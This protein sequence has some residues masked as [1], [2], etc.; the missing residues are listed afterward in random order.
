MPSCKL[1]PVKCL[2]GLKGLLWPGSLMLSA[3]WNVPLHQGWFGRSERL[4]SW[5]PRE[6]L[7]ITAALYRY[8]WARL[9]VLMLELF[10]MCSSPKEPGHPQLKLIDVMNNQWLTMFTFNQRAPST[11]DFPGLLNYAKNPRSIINQRSFLNNLTLSLWKPVWK[12]RINNEMRSTNSSNHWAL[13]MKK[14]L[15][16]ALVI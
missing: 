1:R 11:Q 14:S 15:D 3:L 8:C 9:S 5:Y 13:P 6:H 12:V 16:K 7:T 2:L 10:V 4:P